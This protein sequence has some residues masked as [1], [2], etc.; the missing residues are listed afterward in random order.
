MATE[1]T[2]KKGRGR[3]AK[4]T[5]NEQDISAMKS[6]ISHLA[7]SLT[8]ANIHK[9]QWE[10]K[11]DELWAKNDEARSLIS[12][13]EQVIEDLDE[14]V[15]SQEG[16]IDNQERAYRRLSNIVKSLTESLYYSSEALNNI[17]GGF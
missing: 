3:P 16:E 8:E 17:A 12:K 10:T 2:P 1:Q 11:C 5:V 13:L 14:K 6:R 9:R 7:N 4:V 15:K